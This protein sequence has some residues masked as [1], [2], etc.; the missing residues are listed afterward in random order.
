M[1]TP[2]IFGNVYV[3]SGTLNQ[4]VRR[5]YYPE[6]EEELLDVIKQALEQHPTEE[7]ELGQLM[8][9]CR[10]RDGF[11]EDD[12]WIASESAL[13]KAGFEVRTEER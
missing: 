2:T 13:R 8:L 6:T 1:K 9:I 11:F 5:D 12:W 7:L 10:S 3:K 4:A